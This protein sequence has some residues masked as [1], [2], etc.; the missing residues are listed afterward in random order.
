MRILGRF[1]RTQEAFFSAANESSVR[2]DVRSAHQG[3]SP[4]LSAGLMPREGM[5]AL[6]DPKDTGE[7]ALLINIYLTAAQLIYSF[8]LARNAVVTTPNL[9]LS[10]FANPCS[11]GT[12]A[13]QR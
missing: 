2:T 12:M 13:V 1:L 5:T 3:F 8:F 11:I 6:R 7:K 4:T 10:V 9:L